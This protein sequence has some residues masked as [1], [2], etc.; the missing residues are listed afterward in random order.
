[1]R[2]SENILS[3]WGIA[4]LV[5][6]MTITSCVR[7]QQGDGNVLFE[8]DIHNPMRPH[9]PFVRNEIQLSVSSEEVQSKL[10]SI[11]FDK[12]CCDGVDET[13]LLECCCPDV[14]KLFEEKLSEGDWGFIGKLTSEDEVFA[15]CRYHPDYQNE[16]EKIEN[17]FLED[18]NDEE[19]N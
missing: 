12:A 15:A 14:L 2:R 8:M 6:A 7:D 18:D 16:F 10:S 11:Y 9:L 1:M 5:V 4:L 3:S 19:W 13:L 17:N